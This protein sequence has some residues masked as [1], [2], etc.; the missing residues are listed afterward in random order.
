MQLISAEKKVTRTEQQL[1]GGSDSGLLTQ[2][3]ADHQLL[4]DAAC[5]AA[6]TDRYCA[7]AGQG[8]S[9]GQTQRH[10]IE[11]G[12]SLCSYFTKSVDNADAIN[13]KIPQKINKKC[14]RNPVSSNGF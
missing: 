5:P 9:L 3:L 6:R 7:G 2:D 13:L 10:G 8:A 1:V 11:Q 14:R 12:M 4:Y